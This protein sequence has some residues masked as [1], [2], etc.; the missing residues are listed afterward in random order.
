MDEQRRLDTFLLATDEPGH[1][2][3]FKGRSE[4]SRCAGTV[5]PS[6]RRRIIEFTCI[7][8]CTSIC[9]KL[10][11]RTYLRSHGHG[12]EP[13]RRVLPEKIDAGMERS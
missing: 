6:V 4:Q 9:L 2:K 12:P 3:K 11:P 10:R 8:C 5:R 1:E 13:K 7:L